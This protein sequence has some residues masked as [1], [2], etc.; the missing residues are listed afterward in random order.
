MQ[1]VTVTTE[2]ERPREEIFEFLDDL[3]NRAAFND[4]FLDKWKFSGPTVGVGAKA[5]ARVDAPG[6]Q[7]YI[8]FEIIE[9][10]SP[11]KL[12]EEGLGGKGKRRIRSTYYLSDRPGGGTDLE[13]KHEWIES[14]RSERLI[15]PLTRAFV[16]R[17]NGKALRRLKK[18]LESS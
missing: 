11:Q 16:K 18:H 13:L 6:G 1:P 15:T 4:H 7:D 8:D 3:T 9:A 14:P 10:D 12:V 5:N 2:I 17:T